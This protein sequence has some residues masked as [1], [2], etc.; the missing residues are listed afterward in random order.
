MIVIPQ[1]LKVFISLYLGWIVLLLFTNGFSFEYILFDMS[2]QDVQRFEQLAVLPPIFVL[3]AYGLY[4]WC[5]AIETP[6]LSSALIRLLKAKP[7][8]QKMTEDQKIILTLARLCKA[9]ECEGRPFTD[10]EKKN[11]IINSRVKDDMLKALGG[12]A[13]IRIDVH[14]AGITTS[15]TDEFDISDL[16]EG[17]L[18]TAI[19]ASIISQSPITK[20]PQGSDGPSDPSSV[21]STPPSKL[22]QA[23]D[24]IRAKLNASG[25]TERVME[26]STTTQLQAT[27]VPARNAQTTMPG[28]SPSTSQTASPRPES[29]PTE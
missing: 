2:Y 24:R 3:M 21:Q 13:G 9:A 7:T 29:E 20:M 18:K 11:F 4:R 1:K 12:R 27:F 23:G 28:S 14:R 16:P 22:A 10:E 19:E 26:P 25:F 5:V 15:F 6:R 17:E 8:G